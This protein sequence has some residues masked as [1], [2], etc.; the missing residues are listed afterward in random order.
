MKSNPVGWFEIYVEDSGRARAFY[1]AVL[2]TTLEQLPSPE[3]EMW[4]FPS[5][6]EATG[7]AGALVRM[8]GMPAGGNSTIVYFMCDDCAIEEGRAAANGGQ[9]HKPKMS[10]GPYGFISLV[11]DTEG[12]MIG[13]HSM[14]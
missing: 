13:L 2:G 5:S 6:R 12:N 9:V 1:E 10:I 11:T 3:I 7:A 14:Q 4:A 8:D